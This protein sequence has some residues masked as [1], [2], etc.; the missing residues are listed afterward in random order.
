VG[1]AGSRR[2]K[3]NL[4][5]GSAGVDRIDTVEFKKTIQFT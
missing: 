3:S 1:Q 4:K 2:E 5:G